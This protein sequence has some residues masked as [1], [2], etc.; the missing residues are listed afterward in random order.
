MKGK[1][2]PARFT[3]RAAL[4]VLALILVSRLLYIWHA[5]HPP[6]EGD[7]IAYDTLGR[8][9][10]AGR[11]YTYPPELLY[12]WQIDERGSDVPTARR[13]PLFP[14]LLSLGYRLGIGHDG[15]RIVQALLATLTA[16]LMYRIALRI[17][18]GERAALLTMLALAAYKPFL[19]STV[20]LATEGLFLP[21][22][23]ASALFFLRAADGGRRHDFALSGLALG[24]ASLTRPVTYLVP[25]VYLG[26]LAFRRPRPWL[27]AAILLGA[28]AVAVSPWVIRNQLVFGEFQPSFTHT[29]F[30]FYMGT[31]DRQLSTPITDD[32]QRQIRGMDEFTM[33]RYLAHLG[34][35]N[36]RRDPLHFARLMGLKALQA[37]F[38]IDLETTASPTPKTLVGNGIAL[39]ATLAGF[40]VLLRG[41][42]PWRAF[43]LAMAGYF[44][45]ILMLS[46][47]GL[48]FSLPLMLFTS[49]AIG[50]FGDWLLDR[51]FARASA[52]RA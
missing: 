36:I 24:L 50:V 12:P 35:E 34:V 41:R 23:G 16:W 25:V 42:L 21:L 40:V 1:S 29:G 22:V 39:L 44:L 15:M 20:T 46:V 14:V 26:F 5:H 30:N 18:V 13:P 28:M 6:I 38:Y 19:D 47:S 51:L 8:H 10:A 49:I 43:P 52:A 37:W 27:G 2:K 11:G 31:L 45:V 9:L 3:S 33:D 4:L 17:G 7:E 32:L 48:R